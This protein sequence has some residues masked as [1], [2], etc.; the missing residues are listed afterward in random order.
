M[1][2]SMTRDGNIPWWNFLNLD[3]CKEKTFKK[4]Q[5]L[6]K[7]G[8]NSYN[9]DHSQSEQVLK[10]WPVCPTLSSWEGTTLKRT[11]I[12]ENA[13]KEHSKR[14]LE[15]NEW[16]PRSVFHVLVCERK[17]TFIQNAASGDRKTERRTST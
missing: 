3:S 4:T 6:S 12:W 11:E 2:S 1:I 15:S 16:S 17:E 8:R 5:N 7:H 13:R 14:G 9:V 10:W